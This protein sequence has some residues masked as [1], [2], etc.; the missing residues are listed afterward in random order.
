MKSKVL[1]EGYF[2]LEKFPQKGGWTYIVLSELEKPKA[3]FGM[4]K[5]NGKID[6]HDLVGV[7]LM[8]YGNGNLFLPVN[9]KIRKIISKE[10]GDSVKL[11]LTEV[12]AEEREEVFTE[13]NILACIREEPLAWEKFQQL[14]QETKDHEL[15]EILHFQLESKKIEKII[16]LIEKLKLS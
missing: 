16:L 13:S 9:A 7:T 12:D 14:P 3:Y 15:Q 8:P 11:L 6:N 10:A 4:M 5:V 2:E 1:I